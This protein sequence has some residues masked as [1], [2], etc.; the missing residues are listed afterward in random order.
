MHIRRESYIYFDSLEIVNK[1]FEELPSLKYLLN[2]NVKDIE[3]ASQ[4]T[5]SSDNPMSPP[6]KVYYDA[7]YVQLQSGFSTK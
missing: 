2:Y 7:C 3:Q 5:V 4:D 1:K 6:V